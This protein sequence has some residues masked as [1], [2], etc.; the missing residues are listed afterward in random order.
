MSQFFFIKHYVCRF[1]LQNPFLACSLSLALC[2]KLLFFK[3]HEIRAIYEIHFRHARHHFHYVPN[4]FLRKTLSNVHHACLK[5]AMLIDN[6]MLAHARSSH[7]HWIALRACLK[8]VL[9]EG[10]RVN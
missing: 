6:T 9:F 2:H 3:E 10:C 4:V 8:V 1:L 5:I 7:T